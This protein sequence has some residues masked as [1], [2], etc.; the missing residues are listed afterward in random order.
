MG[1][2]PTVLKKR[3]APRKRQ[4]RRLCGKAPLRF[5]G[6]VHSSLGRFGGVGLLAIAA[7]SFTCHV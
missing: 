5:S 2:A 3:K 1:Q 6:A 7:S 4:A